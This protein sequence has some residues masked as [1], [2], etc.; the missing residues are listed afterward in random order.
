MEDGKQNPTALKRKELPVPKPARDGG[1][2]ISRCYMSCL[3]QG[4]HDG[5][6]P[7]R[8]QGT[9]WRKETLSYTLQA[10]W[11]KPLCTEEVLDAKL[12]SLGCGAGRMGSSLFA[13]SWSTAICLHSVKPRDSLKSRRLPVSEQPML[14]QYPGPT[15]LSPLSSYVPR[16]TSDK[17]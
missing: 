11:S 2:F 15:P 7:L 16:G 10:I 1:S 4:G 6:I 12:L 8:S 14:L 17:I 5:S 3:F 9:V 13:L